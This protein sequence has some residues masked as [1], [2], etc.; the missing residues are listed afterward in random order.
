[1]PRPT[2]YDQLYV[3]LQ[4]ERAG[5]F[6][7]VKKLIPVA[8]AFYPCCSYHIT[9]SFFFPRVY[10][11]DKSD[12][13]AA[14]FKDKA[15]VDKIIDSRKE[16]SESHW[17]FIQADVTD[18]LDSIPEVDL[19]IVLYGGDVLKHAFTKARPKGN[20]LTSS[21]FSADTFLMNDPRYN[22]LFNVAFQSGEYRVLKSPP[23]RKAKKKAFTEAGVF[24]DTLVYRV[25]Q[26]V[27]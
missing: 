3:N 20:I 21:D 12:T 8:S 5:L 17:E 22:C 6:R 24:R 1:M 4:F 10:Y 7:L 27:G 16:V 18:S 11:L 19:V 2:P 23:E 13:A 26:K 25:Y 9:P 15:Q 14:F